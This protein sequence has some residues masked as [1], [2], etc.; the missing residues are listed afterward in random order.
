MTHSSRLILAWICCVAAARVASGQAQYIEGYT[1]CS[2][3]VAGE[4]IEFHV[5][6]SSPSYQIEIVRDGLTPQLIAT[7]PPIAGALYPVPPAG[8]LGANWPVSYTWE[9]PASW[10][11]GS[12]YARFVAAP[13]SSRRHPFVIRRQTP[14][15]L[16][17]IAFCMDYNT[18]NAYN[19]W[20]GSSLYTGAP[21]AIRVS[22]RRPYGVEDGLGK[23]AYLPVQCHGRLEA[24]GYVLE[25][26]TE[27]DIENIPGLLFA[28]DV[29]IFSAHI[30]Y[31]SRPFLDAL[32]A[33]HARG[34]HL[35][36]F[37]ANDL[38]WQVRF[39]DGGDTMVCYK[40]AAIPYDPL[41][42]VNNDLVTTH[43]NELL[44]NRPGEAL[45]GVT[46]QANSGG[47]YLGGDYTVQNASHWFFAGTGLQNGQTV[48]QLL[49]SGETDGIGRATPPVVDVLLAARLSQPATSQTP[50]QPFDTPAMI[51][52]EDS[53]GYGFPNGRGGQVFSAGTQGFCASFATSTPSHVATRRMLR[54]LVNHMLASPPPPALLVPPRPTPSESPL[55][56]PH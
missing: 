38:W 10:A 50:P 21:S 26:F 40:S 43:W 42:G 2:S 14:G 17:R 30:E 54:N 25:Y 34:A 37:S 8:W 53:P 32:W 48:G 49:A 45:E 27:W 13:G 1:T 33:H 28:Y 4:T 36:F 5:S 12:Y 18:R 9:V 44:L 47:F 56:W 23:G 29:V 41:Y 15:T 55:S 24:E 19:S 20:G 7:S 51:Y 16:S 35:A 6:T 39:E 11:T 3:Y 52:Y 31:N 46:F 22:F